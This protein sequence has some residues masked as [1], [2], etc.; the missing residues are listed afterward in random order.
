MSGFFFNIVDLITTDI[1]NL[2]LIEY[3]KTQ[4]VITL[5][6]IIPKSNKYQL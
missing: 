6:R 2:C 3:V 4:M 5:N 1:P